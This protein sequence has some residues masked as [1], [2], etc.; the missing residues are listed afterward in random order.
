[1]RKDRR[2]THLLAIIVMALAVLA[3]PRPLQGQERQYVV[4]SIGTFEGASSSTGY[5]VNSYGQVVGSAAVPDEKPIAWHWQNDDLR[6]INDT[7]HWNYWYPQE[8]G[9]AYDVSDADQIVGGGWYV[10]PGDALPWREVDLF[11]MQAYITRPAV[12]SDFGTPYPG[13]AATNLGALGPEVWLSSVATAVSNANH[14]VGWADLSIKDPPPNWKENVYHAFLVV[15]Q[16]NGFFV[17][18]DGDGINDLM[19]DLGTLRSGDEV[20]SATDVNDD[21]VI[22]GYSYGPDPSVGYSAFRIVP[23]GGSWANLDAQATN[24]LMQ[25]LGSLGGLNSWAHGINNNGVI[26]GEADTWDLNT[27]AFVWQGGVMTDLG[28]LGGDDSC[29]HAISDSGIIVGW[30]EDSD[31]Q[32]H[33]AMWIDD[34]E[35]YAIID[36][37]DQIILTK[38]WGL[39][40]ARDINDSGEVAGWGTYSGSGDG[41]GYEAFLLERAT[42]EDLAKIQVEEEEIG[43]LGDAAGDDTTT[44]DTSGAAPALTLSPIFSDGASPADDADVETP[45][46]PVAPLCG[47]GFAQFLPLTLLGIVGLKARRR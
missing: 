36:L 6:D 18:A 29:A 1:M 7:V 30:S 10:V 2:W 47:F 42:A 24:S 21:G 12:M 20:S 28:T 46:A 34:G 19:I 31:R 3:L 43:D 38:R 41:T 17:D 13:D 39:V 25:P 5:A 15:P 4:T 9:E 33:A 44:S 27:H 26:V 22:V 35:G 11:V 16:G 8:R 40:E 23:E 14:V 37:N 45:A 32:R